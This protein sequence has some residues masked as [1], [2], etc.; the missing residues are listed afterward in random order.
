MRRRYTSAI[1]ILVFM[2]VFAGMGQGQ[3]VAPPSPMDS[4][5]PVEILMSLIGKYMD[6]VQ[7]YFD[8]A[9][10]GGEPDSAIELRL[11]AD[12]LIPELEDES[13]LNSILMNVS[14]MAF[15]VEAGVF[16]RYPQTMKVN[17]SGTMGE[18]ELLATES[19]VTILS[20]DEAV[21][22]TFPLEIDEEDVSDLTELIDLEGI[23]TGDL[24]TLDFDFLASLGLLQE[25]ISELLLQY[26]ADV[27]MEYDGLEVT[28]E[29]RA[30]VV[31]LTSI[32][33]G[34]IATL[35]ILDETWELYKVR[36]DDPM[37]GGGNAV[38]LIKDIQ[39]V[40]TNKLPDE[41]LE[42]DTSSLAEVSY[43]E[44]IAI[45]GLKV[46]SVNLAG[47][48]VAADLNLS[49]SEITQGEQVLI[50]SRG[51]DIE[52]LEEQLNATIEYKAPN[53]DWTPIESSY[54]NGVWEAIFTASVSDAPGM[55][56]FR[57]TY[58]DTMGNI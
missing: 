37:G 33:N 48:P 29:G 41:N 5:V 28:P 25:Q 32:D 26:L 6:M 50:T 27:T 57:V 55:Y 45:L 42:I 49:A 35:W 52:D 1:L 36:V 3:V 11:A 9:E 18:V 53:G 22:T 51:M 56:D 46:L 12:I 44:F 24:S 17:L 10:Q 7:H 38:I 16:A 14:K 4:Q 34:M 58:T 30:H 39:L 47:V 20:R 43:D 31:R 40:T 23:L 2:L 8:T 19:D 21:F 13:E 54:V 15:W